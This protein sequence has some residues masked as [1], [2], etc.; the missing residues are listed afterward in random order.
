MIKSLLT[1]FFSVSSTLVFSQVKF[2]VKAGGNLSNME[3]KNPELDDIGAS[4]SPI[5]SFHLGGFA[6]IGLG[7][8]MYFQPALL[9]SG[10]GYKI[11]YSA[12]QSGYTFSING[13]TNLSI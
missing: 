1:I 11:D 6:E 5:P 13:K 9:V 7:K 2:G 10:K 8:K 4:P 3:V 12:S